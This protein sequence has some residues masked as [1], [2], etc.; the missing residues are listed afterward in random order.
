[1]TE[2]VTGVDLVQAQLRIAGGATLADLALGDQSAIQLGGYAV[3]C[4]VTLVPG[5]SPL[6]TVRMRSEL[7]SLRYA[8]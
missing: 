6:V 7:A 3:Q 2:E 5:P 8:S 1:M 4:R